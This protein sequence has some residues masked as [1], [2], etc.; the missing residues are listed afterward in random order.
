MIYKAL[1]SLPDFIQGNPH[2]NPGFCYLYSLFQPAQTL[3]RLKAGTQPGNKLWRVTGG[4]CSKFIGGP[5]SSWVHGQR[6]FWEPSLIFTVSLY[7]YPA[8][9]YA[10]D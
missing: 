8:F 9:S 1:L 5:V 4:C 6:V 7:T 10:L 2:G 3:G